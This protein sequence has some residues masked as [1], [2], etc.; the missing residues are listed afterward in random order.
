MLV[1]IERTVHQTAHTHTHI[2]IYISQHCPAS[3]PKQV[4]PGF[5]LSERV[6]GNVP[7]LREKDILDSWCLSGLKPFSGETSGPGLADA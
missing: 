3:R 2:Y 4:L 5:C 7:A 1:L 6:R